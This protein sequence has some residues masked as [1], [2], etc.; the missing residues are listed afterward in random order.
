MAMPEIVV[1]FVEE[2]IQWFPTQ[3]ASVSIDASAS[4][5][6]AGQTPLLFEWN[7]PEALGGLS[8]A[9]TNT[10]TLSYSQISSDNGG[11]VEQFLYQALQFNVTVS[12]FD[13]SR[14]S[15]RSFYL[16]LVDDSDSSLAQSTAA[17]CGI[18]TSSS[19]AYLSFQ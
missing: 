12:N 3:D 5:D 11:D 6:P 15:I 1:E 19:E 16:Y 18:Y 10:L 14:S 13:S 2:R 4:Y 9:S 17:S 8:C 7:C